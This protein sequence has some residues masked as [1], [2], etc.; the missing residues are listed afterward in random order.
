M[1]KTSHFRTCRWL[2]KNSLEGWA[3]IKLLI[4]TFFCTFF[5]TRAPVEIGGSSG[6]M[7]LL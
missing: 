3:N 7:Q 1:T 5:Q 2:G 4:V 6:L